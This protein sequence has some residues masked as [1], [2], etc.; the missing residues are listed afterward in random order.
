MKTIKTNLKK[1]LLVIIIIALL[2]GGSSLVCVAVA[3]SIKAVALCV[4]GVV[5]VRLGYEMLNNTNIN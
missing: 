2:M 5:L 4:V 3:T 1:L